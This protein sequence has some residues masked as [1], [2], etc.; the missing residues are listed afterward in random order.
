MVT[1]YCRY[2]ETLHTAANTSVTLVN[3]FVI[4]QSAPRLIIIGYKN[5]ENKCEQGSSRK[6]GIS[7]LSVLSH[8]PAYR[9]VQGGSLIYNSDLSVIV[10]EEHVASETESV[11]GDRGV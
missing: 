7:S 1:E 9:S 6:I 10:R 11:S 2:Q 8:H 5:I 4:N 3:R